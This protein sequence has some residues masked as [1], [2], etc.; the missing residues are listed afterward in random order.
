M[1]DFMN[2]AAITAKRENVLILRMIPVAQNTITQSVR[3]VMFI[4]R[5]PATRLMTWPN[6]ALAVQFARKE[7]VCVL[8]RIRTA[9]SV[10]ARNPPENAFPSQ[11]HFVLEQVVF[12]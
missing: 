11:A 8:I 10:S 1:K 9:W 3:E 6:G 12:L 2:G 4:G 5:M 7:N